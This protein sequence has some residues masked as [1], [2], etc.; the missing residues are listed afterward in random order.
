MFGPPLFTMIWI[1]ITFIEVGNRELLFFVP[2]LGWEELYMFAKSPIASLRM[3]GELGDAIEQT[4]WLPWG[5]AKDKMLDDY[6]IDDDSWYTYQRG[7]KRGKKKI[8]KA[9]AD[10]FPIMYAINRFKA[11]DTQ[12]DFFIK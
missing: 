4:L 11:Y 12:K 8:W 7:K 5:L 1:T 3:V 10:I 6:D 9:W 2:V